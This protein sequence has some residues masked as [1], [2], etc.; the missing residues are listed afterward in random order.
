[1][2][3]IFVKEIFI[4]GFDFTKFMKKT[5]KSAITE[6]EKVLE[7]VPICKNKKKKKKKERAENQPLY[8]GRKILRYG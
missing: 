7:V 6:L 5:T 8:W 3:S 4:S 2:G 1:M